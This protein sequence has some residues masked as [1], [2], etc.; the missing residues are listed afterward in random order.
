M[1]NSTEIGFWIH[2]GS[3]I[4]AGGHNT[5]QV[6][7][8]LLLLLLLLLL[9]D[10]PSGQSPHRTYAAAAALLTRATMLKATEREN[11]ACCNV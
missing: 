5:G 9:L 1:F 4:N 7:G 11:E 2:S 3:S 6:M 10:I 8:V